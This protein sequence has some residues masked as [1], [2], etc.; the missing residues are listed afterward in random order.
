VLE[1]FKR[2]RTRWNPLT[3]LKASKHMIFKDKRGNL[4]NIELFEYW[5][6]ATLNQQ[7]ISEEFVSSATSSTDH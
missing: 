6:S 2:D 3:Q 1:I 7:A 5:P 4:R